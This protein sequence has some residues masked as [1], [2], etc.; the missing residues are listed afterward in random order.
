METLSCRS[1]RSARD[2]PKTLSLVQYELATVTAAVS[3]VV[4]AT[5]VLLAGRPLPP[6]T[7]PLVAGEC[8]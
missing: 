1:R 8:A 3:P 2:P 6:V 4:A 5:A 7:V